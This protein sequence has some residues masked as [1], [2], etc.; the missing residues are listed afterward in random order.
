MLRNFCA[1]LAVVSGTAAWGG[2]LIVVPDDPHPPAPPAVTITDWSG[3][4]AGV[5]LSYDMM[6]VEDLSFGTGEFDANGAG[7]FGFVGY[8]F[9][10]G[11]WVFGPELRA[12]A[13]WIEGTD[14]FMDPF[15]NEWSAEARGR[16]GY[17]VGKTLP[18][19]SAGYIASGFSADHDGGGVNLANDTF[20]GFTLGVGIDVMLGNNTFLRAEYQHIEYDDDQLVFFGGTDPH[21]TTASSDRISV[22]FAKKF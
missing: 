2:N 3:V 15:K 18:F 19:F 20:S 9:Q 10:A 4:Y 6:T 7:L 16:L 14:I 21:D 5:G 1:A 12:T 17:T 22:G 13:S 8:N 11:R